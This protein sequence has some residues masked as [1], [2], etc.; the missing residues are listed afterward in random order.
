MTS[1]NRHKD[2]TFASVERNP[3]WLESKVEP[4]PESGC[5]IWSGA[6][7][8]G[9]YGAYTIGRGKGSRAVR[10]H[11]LAWEIHNGPIPSGMVVMHSCDVRSC[12]NPAHLSVG[13]Q[14]ENLADAARKGRAKGP[15]VAMDAVTR[16]RL[17]FL[18]VGEHMSQTRLAA[19]FGIS[20]SAV[21]RI[22][23]G[24]R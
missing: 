20:Q 18:A 8:P 5:W 13:T 6:D 21:S 9:G 10:P 23:S 1:P 19:L 14:A 22:R 12:C 16:K 3:E 17:R 4:V 2:G 15:M 11:R 7:G 24:E